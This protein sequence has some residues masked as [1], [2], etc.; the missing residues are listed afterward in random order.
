V[1]H[2]FDI[3]KPLQVGGQAVLE[4][5]MMRAPGMVATAVRK[6]D[7]SIVI[8]REAHVSLTERVR[9]L[10]LP[11]LRGA[12]GLVEMLIIGVQTLNFSADVALAASGSPSEGA[13]GG[14]GERADPKQNRLG[15][16]ATLV[17]ALLAGLALFFVTPLLAATAFF[18]LDQ[19]PFRFNLIAG[20]IR[21]GI[22]LAYLVA[23]SRLKDVQRLFAYHG[24]EHKAVVAFERGEPLNVASAMSQTRF[25]PRC[26]T[27]FVLVVLVAAIALFAILDSAL[28]SVFGT[29]TLGTRVIT[30]VL[31]LPLVGGL[32]YE[33]IRLSSRHSATRVGAM[34]VAPGLWLQRITTREPDEDQVTV[35]LAALQAA[36]GEEESGEA[37]PSMAGL[38]AR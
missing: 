22:F 31:L 7:G 33:F 28:I 37:S 20:T 10:K 18:N 24:A 5:V 19:D 13:G 11:I 17:M 26:G 27:S 6:P 12:V 16:A 4:G 3:S 35:A 2:R 29:I 25:H 34:I 14:G 21:M 38:P 8:Q 32:S 36:L 1:K 15:L 30:H 9:L 23:I